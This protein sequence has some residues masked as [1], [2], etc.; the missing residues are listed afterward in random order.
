MACGKHLVLNALAHK[1]THRETIASA[2][3][4]NYFTLLYFTS[5][6]LGLGWVSFHCAQYNQLIRR[7]RRRKKNTMTIKLSC[8][9]GSCEPS[10]LGNCTYP[11]LE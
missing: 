8:T 7:F 5:L 10:F 9:I 4:I 11:E 1:H 2:K 6:P 3:H